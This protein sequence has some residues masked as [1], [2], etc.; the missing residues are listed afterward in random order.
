MK[1]SSRHKQLGHFLLNHR[2]S[3]QPDDGSDPLS[4]YKTLILHATPTQQVILHRYAIEL[5][6]YQGHI[7]LLHQLQSWSIPTF[8]LNMWDLGQHGLLSTQ[9]CSRCLRLLKEQWRNTGYRMNKD[10]LIEFGFQSGLF[11]I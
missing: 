5:L 4:P 11:Y 7:D 3:I 6:K 8:P 10:Q 9:Q 1:C 2:Y